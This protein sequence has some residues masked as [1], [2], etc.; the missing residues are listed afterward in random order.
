MSI[1]NYSELQTAVAAWLKRG[2]LT[3]R[4]PDFIRL[5]EIR[6]KSMLDVRDL[7]VTTD[8][9]TIPSSATVAL[10]SDFKSPVAL[11]LDDINPRE[12]LDQVLPENLPYNTVPNRPL[13]WAIDGSNIRF[14]TPA[15]AEYPV[16]FRY[17]QLF[18]LSDTNPTNYI[19]TQYPDVYLF[20]ALFEAADFS[21]DEQ[22]AVKW[23]AKSRDAIKR[24]SD[25]ENSNQKFVPLVT[26]FGQI[27][28]R[29]FNIYRGY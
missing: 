11:W 23:D 19:L 5:A 7:E 8:L 3:A 13:Y 16:K 14:Q 22:N 12:R 10:P 1:S 6:I 20:G 26:E 15:N 2:D 25:Q 24:A 21:F 29:R 9:V 28:K 27:M 18:E 4:I 17:M